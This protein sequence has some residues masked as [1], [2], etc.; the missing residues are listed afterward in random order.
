MLGYE[1]SGAGTYLFG[2]EESYGCLIGTHARDKDAIVATM[3]L[4]EAAA[5]Y[6][7][8]GK[9]L[10][11]AMIEM[12]ERYGYWLDDIT[13]ITMKG[14]DGIAKIQ[15][16]METLRKSTPAQIAGYD[17]L[18]VRDYSADTIT[19]V[20]TGAVTPTGL[21]KSNVLYYEL[22][23]DTWLCVR[24]SGTEPKIKFY[25]GVK[26]TSLENAKE[27]SKDFGEKIQAL[28]DSIL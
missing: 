20:K 26:G 1:Q 17:V 16:I 18:K 28:I 25:Y 15:S 4:C 14:L 21:P 27:L 22:T 2:F 9:T 6:K 24:P 12:Y 23:D 7:S 11:D 5:Y 10:W 8:Q 19:D 3:A 13:T